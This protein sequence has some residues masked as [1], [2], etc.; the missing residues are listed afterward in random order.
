MGGSCFFS[1][2][3]KDRYMFT[4]LLLRFSLVQR[5]KD[6]KKNSQAKTNFINHSIILNSQ[7]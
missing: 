2:E 6:E 5:Q 1:L 4:S 3:I 7:A